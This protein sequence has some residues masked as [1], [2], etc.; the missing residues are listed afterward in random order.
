MQ[1]FLRF[2]EEG[3]L[4]VIPEGFDHLLFITSLYFI[5]P[6]LKSLLIQCSI[7]T[8]AH[9]LSLAL[10]SLGIWVGNP[11]WIEPIIALSIVTSSIIAIFQIGK[12]KWHYLVLFLFG[13]I[14]GLGFANAL[15]SFELTKSNFLVSLVGFNIGVEIAQICAL[16]FLY[17][18]VG[19]FF[20]TK[21]WYQQWICLPC[22]SI[23]G[24]IAMY[25]TISRIPF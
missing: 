16:L 14:H 21:P 23:I 5:D 8:L 10:S 9:S 4:H 22:C 12:N 2:V 20:G 1:V 17:V 11:A 15:N 13:L 3:F 19:K 18:F 6:R 25:W 24:C 7:F